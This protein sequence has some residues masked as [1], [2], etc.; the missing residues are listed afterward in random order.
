MDWS[1]YHPWIFHSAPFIVNGPIFSILFSFSNIGLVYFY[2]RK[3][4]LFFIC[5][6]NMFGYWYYDY[7]YFSKTKH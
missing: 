5:S 2:T 3:Y 1:I 6:R 4:F 7:V